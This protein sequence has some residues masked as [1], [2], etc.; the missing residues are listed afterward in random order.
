[1]MDD[2]AQDAINGMGL[3]FGLLTAR[4]NDDVDG[5]YA[6]LG[7]KGEVGED[8]IVDN[9]PF[10]TAQAILGLADFGLSC[11]LIQSELTGMKV[12]T[13][14]QTLSMVANI[15]LPD[16]IEKRERGY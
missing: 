16:I 7:A 10:V 3:T 14:L 1:V 4:H 5:F 8:G 12:S 15:A 6:L 9:D 2:K 13:L 11:L